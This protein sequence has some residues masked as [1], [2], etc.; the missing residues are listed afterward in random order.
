[1]V[2]IDQITL[3]ARKIAEVD[4]YQIQDASSEVKG[5]WGT[6]FNYGHVN[7][8]TAGSIPKFSMENVPRPHQLRRTILDLAAEDKKYHRNGNN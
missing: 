3:F 4:L 5:F 7:I 6:L 8:Q 1:M 2:D